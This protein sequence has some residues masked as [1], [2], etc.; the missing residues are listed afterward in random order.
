MASKN[1]L[2]RHSL[3]Q[4]IDG[5]IQKIDSAIEKIVI[6]FSK[7]YGPIKQLGA[8]A[9]F[10]HKVDTVEKQVSAVKNKDLINIGKDQTP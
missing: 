9:R 3:V 5:D 2:L 7:M 4:R 6:D 8:V 10:E 1:G